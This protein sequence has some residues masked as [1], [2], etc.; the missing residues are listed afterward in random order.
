[1]TRDMF[2]IRISPFQGFTTIP[3]IFSGR[4]PMLMI[5]VFQ[6]SS[7]TEPRSDKNNIGYS[8]IGRHNVIT[9]GQNKATKWSNH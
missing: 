1:M 2:G 8:P 7:K 6:T 3:H 5:K 4:C 9:Y